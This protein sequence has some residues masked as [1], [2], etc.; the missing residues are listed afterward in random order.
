VRIKPQDVTVRLAKNE[1]G[2]KI[3]EL[4]RKG[5]F[6]F[7]DWDI[8]W[9]D[10]FPYWLVAEYKG[11]VV[12]CI[13]VLPGKPVGRL[14]MLGISPS[15]SRRLR[16]LA[17]RHLTSTGQLVIGMYGGQAASG[18]IPFELKSYKKVA[19]RRGWV[20]LSTGDLMLRRVD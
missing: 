10:I 19:Q 13:Q 15:V 18:M 20:V 6:Y 8:D 14:E 7:D 9:S 11:E 12:G 17:V 5:G 16:S 1:D 3:A 4:A 2:E